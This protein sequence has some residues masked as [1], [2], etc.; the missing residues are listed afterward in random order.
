MIEALEAAGVPAHDVLERFWP[1]SRMKAWLICWM[2]VIARRLSGSVA[3]T[4]LG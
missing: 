3:V 1:R 4:A 2:R